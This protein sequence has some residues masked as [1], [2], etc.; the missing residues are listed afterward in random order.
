MAIEGKDEIYSGRIRLGMVGGGSGAF[1]GGVHRMVSRLDDHYTFVAGALSSTPEKAL[2]SGRELG[3]DPERT[4]GSYEEMAEKEAA[5]EDGIE[6]VAIVT[7]NHMHFGPAKAFLEK[8]I[9]VICDKPVT[10]NLEDA[11]ALKEI[12]REVSVPIVANKLTICAISGAIFFKNFEFS[13]SV[14]FFLRD[15]NTFSPGKTFIIFGIVT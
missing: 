8:G 15:E 4:Y 9:H 1:I 3:L 13:N 6:A 12:V 7:P 2:A 11:K 10:S 14:S 5:R